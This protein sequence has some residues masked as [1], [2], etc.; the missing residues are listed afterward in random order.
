M[1]PEVGQTAPDFIV[2]DTTGAPRALSE[3]AATRD[4]VLIFYRGHW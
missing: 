1:T 2:P 3:L 4:L